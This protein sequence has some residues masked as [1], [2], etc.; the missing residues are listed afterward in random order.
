[1]ATTLP[2]RRSTNDPVV[3]ATDSPRWASAR[4]LLG[5]VAVGYLTVLAALVA[6]TVLPLLWGWSTYVVQSESMAPAVRGGD[7]LITARVDPATIRVSQ[8]VVVDDPAVPGRVLSHRVVSVDPDGKLLTRG[9][10]NAQNDSTPVAP[11][12]VHGLARL[13]VPYV[14]LPGLWLSEGRYAVLALWLAGTAAAV[15]AAATDPSRGRRR[16]RRRAPRPDRPARALAATGGVTACV[17]LAPLGALTPTVTGSEVHAAFTATG[18]NGVNTFAARA[19]WVAPDASAVTVAKTLPGYL[20]GAVQPSAAYRVHAHVTDAG[21]PDPGS[22]TV[23]ADL[24]A[25]TAGETSTV[26][27]SGAS[28]LGGV[29]YNHSSATLTSGA[30]TGVKGYTLT[31]TDTS[32]NSRTRTGYTVLVDGTAPAATDVDTTNKAGGTAGRPESGDTLTLTYS[33]R[34]DP[35]SVMAGWTGSA[36]AVTVRLTKSGN[37]NSISVL[38]PGGATLPLGTVDTA[39]NVQYTSGTIDFTGSTMTQTGG[40]VSLVLGTPSSAPSTLTAASALSW[41]PSSSAYDAAGNNSST[42]TA[43]EQGVSDSNF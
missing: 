17:L 4:V 40:A 7:A 21:D 15:V 6:W 35:Y 28:S 12:R 3:P 20:T 13:R 18:S 22:L 42:T 25:V 9:D 26:L 38:S 16:R 43:T 23:R 30:S 32:G 5:A 39:S 19:D 31:M 1:M 41:T 14:G 33:E 11:D 8:I 34:I 10:A 2:A 36:Q 29:S 37:H 27:T 24:S